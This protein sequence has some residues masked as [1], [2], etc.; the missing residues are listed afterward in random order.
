MQ[1]VSSN[2]GM[3]TL[4]APD[5]TTSMSPMT[6]ACMTGARAVV[7]VVRA[8]TGS[9]E[10]LHHV[11]GL[12]TRAARRTGEHHGFRTMLLNYGA[13]PLGVKSSASS[14]VTRSS[15]APFVR[16]IIGW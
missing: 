9:R 10:L 7:D 5:P 15:G 11:V 4:M 6:L 2:V 3:L 8:Q 13:E 16:R 14:Q 1:S 12:V